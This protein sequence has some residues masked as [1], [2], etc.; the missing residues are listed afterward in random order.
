MK[1]LIDLLNPKQEQLYT[2]IDGSLQTPAP[3]IEEPLIP[4]E[5][6]DEQVFTK[7]KLEDVLPKKQED[8]TAMQSEQLA[9]LLAEVSPEKP[10]SK[11][12]Q[13][14]Q[15]YLALSGKD[16]E[17]LK[18]ARET[19]RM[20]KMGGAIGDALATFINAK[21]QAKA[22]IPG[23][24]VQ[25]G[26][27]LGKIADM[28]Q[29]AP[30]VASDL[31][32]KREALLNQY[33]QM[34]LGERSKARMESEEKRARE[35]NETTLKAAGLKASSKAKE[36]KG[37]TPYQEYMIGK[38]QKKEGKLSDKQTKEVE[39]LDNVL[40]SLNEVEVAKQGVNT[41]RYA[42]AFQS[43]KDII[44]GVESDQNFVALRQMSGTQLFDY[45]KEQ[46]GVSYSVK[47]LQELKNNMPSVEDDDNTFKTKL[48]TV[49]K[50]IERKRQNKLNALEAQGKDVSGF[51]TQKQTQPIDYEPKIENV[52]KANPKATRQ[53]VIDAL[54]KEKKLPEDYK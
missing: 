2:P 31:A 23:V 46:S 52:L 11:Q 19:D 49:R 42:S 37:L 39:G 3:T 4:N 54:I 26:A 17:D 15:D 33:K 8:N 16:S 53:Q 5:T 10:L 38:S 22:K 35:K 36:E 40:S 50:I 30:E 9:P 44:P 25:Q 6:P 48:T 14:L 29:T 20:L 27:G 7:P 12:E 1:S 13:L 41:G 47:E 18:K 32:A 43:G 51:E 24:Q 45:V 21:S 34:A 28:F